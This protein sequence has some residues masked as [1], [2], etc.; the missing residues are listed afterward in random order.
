MNAL[1][2][3]RML[4]GHVRHSTLDCALQH[5]CTCVH[6]CPIAGC[7]A[8]GTLPTWRWP[9]CRWRGCWAWRPGLLT[10]FTTHAWSAAA[11]GWGGR[12]LR[13]L[14][15]SSRYPESVGRPHTATATVPPLLLPPPAA[16]LC[17]C[18][19]R[20]C[21]SYRRISLCRDAAIMLII[22]VGAAPC[23]PAL[24]CAVLPSC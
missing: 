5:P 17:R 4:L 24:R 21:R 19:C 20:W 16:D 13:V 9:L 23:C 6:V 11:G 7:T 18:C 12:E 8:A 15:H 22:H 10:T 2:C 14:Q 3:S 1:L